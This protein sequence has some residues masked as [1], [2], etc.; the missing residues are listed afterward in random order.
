MVEPFVI[1]EH[2][3]RVSASIGIAI[4]HGG[5]EQQD[6]LMNADAAMYH[7]KA[8]G[9]NC[10]CF[11]ETCMN[12]HAY[13][14]V[15]ILHDL[16]KALE[17]HELVL[18]YQPKFEA[19]S[20]KLVGAEALLRWQHPTRGLIPPNDFI[21]LAEKTGLII[22]IGEWVLNTACRQ[23]RLW[24]D[25][26]HR[27]DHWS[28]AVNLSTVQFDHPGL[29]RMVQEALEQHDMEP[30][31]LILEITESTAMQDVDQSMGILQQ[32]YSMGVNI[33]ID[34]FGTGYSSLLYLKRL[35]ASE[36]KID[37]G[38]V[39]DLGHDSEDAAIVSAIVALGRTLNL[40]V[41]AEGVETA[42]QQEFLTHLGCDSLQ[43]FLLGRPLPAD[44]FIEALSRNEIIPVADDAQV[45]HTWKLVAQTGL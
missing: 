9:R 20:K 26:G 2:E 4:H 7:A 38:F 22:P 14:Q 19:R 17:R 8:L 30:R 1:E 11:F 36:I 32:I 25:A 16:R 31:C 34:D 3:L 40:K 39:R 24:R 35:P 29:I 42:E 15:Q 21:P 41:V 44:E 13:E 43:G 28:V 18:H 5:D 37:R 6:L 10:Y 27:T 45:A 33:S 12:A 23:M